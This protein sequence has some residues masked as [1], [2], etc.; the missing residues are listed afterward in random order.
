LLILAIS[1][2]LVTVILNGITGGFIENSLSFIWTVV[3][4]STI[5]GGDIYM[6][7]GGLLV[8]IASVVLLAL[9]IFLARK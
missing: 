6:G 9:Q 1:F 8:V 7:A 5:Q 4:F 3:Q 2:P